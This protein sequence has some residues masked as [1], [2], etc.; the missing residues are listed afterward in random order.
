M[1]RQTSLLG[2]AWRSAPWHRNQPLR[3]DF[4]RC[5]MQRSDRLARNG[6]LQ[7]ARTRNMDEAKRKAK[8]DAWNAT[9]TPHWKAENNESSTMARR[10][11]DH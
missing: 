3:Q 11:F 9:I 6:Y 5:S 7:P 1:I 10:L 8:L 2:I 4:G